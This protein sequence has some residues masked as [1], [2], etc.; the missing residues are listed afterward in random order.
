[1]ATVAAD[2]HAGTP[3]R[4]FKSYPYTSAF[5]MESRLAEVAKDCMGDEAMKAQFAGLTEDITET[6]VS[7]TTTTDANHVALEEKRTVIAEQVKEEVDAIAEAFEK[8][9]SAIEEALTEAKEALESSIDKRIANLT[10]TVQSSLDNFVTAQFVANHTG[11]MRWE[12]NYAL[13]QIAKAGANTE[14]GHA[15]RMF[16]KVMYNP[17][18][19]GYWHPGGEE[20]KQACTTLSNDMKKVDGKDRKLKPAADV[21]WASD[22]DSVRLQG[23]YLSNCGCGGHPRQRQ[24]VGMSRN[25]LAGGVMYNRYN[26]WWGC[27]YLRHDGRDCHHHWSNCYGNWGVKGDYTICTASNDEFKDE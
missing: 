11:D 17:N 15:G 16:Y 24:C 4:E 14:N 3:T 5:T 8:E 13:V 19:P 10:K 25:F 23:S 2:A 20:L 26:S 9:F 12:S 22:G 7:L 27:K 21:D 1:V 18:N 6:V